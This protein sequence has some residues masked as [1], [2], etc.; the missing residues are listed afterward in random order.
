MDKKAHIGNG[1]AHNLPERKNRLA[2]TFHVSVVQLDGRM[3]VAALL[4]APFWLRG[5][6]EVE[7]VEDL[8]LER[9]GLCQHVELGT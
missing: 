5:G 4:T 6:F 9:R 3:H 2:R 8:L 1:A 7:Q